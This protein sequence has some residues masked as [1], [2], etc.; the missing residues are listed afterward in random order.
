VK[1]QLNLHQSHYP[2]KGAYSICMHRDD[3]TTVSLS[4]LFI[5]QNQVIFNYHNGSPCE[6]HSSTTNTLML[7]PH[8]QKHMASLFNN[9]FHS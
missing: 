2:Q 6:N 4:H 7:N 3:A 5:N 9:S 8:T 1:A